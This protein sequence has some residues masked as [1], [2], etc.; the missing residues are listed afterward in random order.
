MIALSRI[1]LLG[2]A[3]TGIQWIETLVMI[4]GIVYYCRN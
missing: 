2:L 1:I 4:V 3:Y